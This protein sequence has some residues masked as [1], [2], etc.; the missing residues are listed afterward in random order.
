[1]DSIDL[2]VAPIRLFVE[3]PRQPQAHLHRAKTRQQ[4]ARRLKPVFLERLLQVDAVEK[5]PCSWEGCR[6]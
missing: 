1:M 4:R 5:G 6:R 2:K 3:G